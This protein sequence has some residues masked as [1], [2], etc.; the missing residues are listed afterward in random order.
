[1][2]EDKHFYRDS[3][4]ETYEFLVRDPLPNLR[5]LAV[6]HVRHA[7]GSRRSER[8]D[9]PLDAMPSLRECYFNNYKCAPPWLTMP[10]GKQPRVMDIFQIVHTMNTDD[11]GVAS[12]EPLGRPNVVSEL[13]E[14]VSTST[15]MTIFQWIFPET[16]CTDAA[17]IAPAVQ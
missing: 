12:R 9:I 8:F 13:T 7:D 4:K 5:S 6:K 11:Q 15:A 17:C 10:V 3:L 1:M 2:F 14:Y 16:F